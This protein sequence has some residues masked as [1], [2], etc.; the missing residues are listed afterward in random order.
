MNV[1][2]LRAQAYNI[3]IFI[4]PNGSKWKKNNI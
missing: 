3:Y 2:M 1:M 4:H